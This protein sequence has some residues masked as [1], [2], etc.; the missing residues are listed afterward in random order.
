M[1]KETSKN[2]RIKISYIICC[3]KNI[4]KKIFFFKQLIFAYFFYLYKRVNSF[5]QSLL[6]RVS[7]YLCLRPMNNELGTSRGLEKKVKVNFA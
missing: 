5:M 3:N 2:K 4:I 1:Q 6:Q 7:F